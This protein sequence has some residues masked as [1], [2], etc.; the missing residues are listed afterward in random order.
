LSESIRI[1]PAYAILLGHTAHKVI[2]GAGAGMAETPM[3]RY[4]AAEA[5]IAIVL[6]NIVA[7]WKRFGKCVVYRRPEKLSNCITDLLYAS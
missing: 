7:G 3:F 2:A 1:F 4:V 6:K 5:R